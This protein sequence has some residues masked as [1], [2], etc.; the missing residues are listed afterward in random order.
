MGQYD[1][2]FDPD[3]EDTV[4]GARLPNAD[5]EAELFE[6]AL[7]AYDAELFTAADGAFKKL[8]QRYPSSYYATFAE[9]KSADCAFHLGQY[10]EALTAYEEFIRLHSKHEAAPYAML[11]IAESHRMQYKGLMND[12]TPLYSAIKQY[13][14]L[15][16]TYPKDSYAS[17]ARKSIDEC[18]EKLAAHEYKVAEFYYKQGQ[19]RSAAHRFK[20]LAKEY[21]D[22]ASAR[23]AARKVDDYYSAHPSLLTYIQT[24]EI[25]EGSIPSLKDLTPDAPTLIAKSALDPTPKQV[26]YRLLKSD[27]KSDAGTEIEPIE[28]AFFKA[29]AP[30]FITSL[31]CSSEGDKFVFVAHLAGRP[32]DEL[33]SEDTLNEDERSLHS[34]SVLLQ[35]HTSSS[36]QYRFE[37]DPAVAGSCEINETSAELHPQGRSIEVRIK[38]PKSF[39]L[40]PFTLDRPYRAVLVLT[41]A[42]T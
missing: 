3:E 7:E 1:P 8:L 2:E 36:R 10:P 11:Q 42:R 15:I 20:R 26:R 25:P 38:H 31:S 21:A 23:A 12:Q 5:A 18:R 17:L 40:T 27:G 39:K 9:L 13:Q 22:T 24:E 19:L 41:P 30:Q 4:E 33:F 28:T 16:D 37:L 29:P 32:S 6:E 14:R 35:P 34:T